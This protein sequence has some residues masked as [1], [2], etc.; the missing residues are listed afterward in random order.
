MRCGRSN[1]VAGANRSDMESIVVYR[2][3]C[4][5]VCRFVVNIVVAAGR[6]RVGSVRLPTD[7]FAR[8]LR[9]T[10][11]RQDGREEKRAVALGAATRTY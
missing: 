9:R 8:R 5:F 7:D 11:A 2:L 4:F 3:Q 1:G 6:C 10:T